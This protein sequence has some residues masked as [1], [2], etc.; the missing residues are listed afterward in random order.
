MYE[1]KLKAI[2]VQFNLIKIK[3]LNDRTTN[4]IF[5]QFLRTTKKIWQT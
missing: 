1:I 2:K 4:F 3:P 5:K